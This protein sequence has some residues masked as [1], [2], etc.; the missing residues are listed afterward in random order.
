[1]N[2]APDFGIASAGFLIGSTLEMLQWVQSLTGAETPDEQRSELSKMLSAACE[3]PHAAILTEL[4]S[5]TELMRWPVQCGNPIRALSQAAAQW[6][7]VKF[8]ED[9]F[10]FSLK[11]DLIHDLG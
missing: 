5:G 4:S 1:M 7:E 3:T 9:D 2:G 6:P 11:P 10:E 8:A